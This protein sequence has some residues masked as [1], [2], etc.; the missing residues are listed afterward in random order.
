M[1]VIVIMGVIY[2]LSVTSFPKQGDEEVTNVDLLSLK[3]YL[4]NLEYEENIRVLCLDDCRDCDIIVDGEKHSTIENLVDDNT[5]VY[6]YDYLLG[7]QERM[8][9]VYFNEEDVQEDVCFSYTIDKQGVGDQVLVEF[10]EEVY[11]FS[12]YITDTQKYSSM[13][14]CLSAKAQLIEEVT[15]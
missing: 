8:K 1:I 4:T 10:K 2:T 14:E 7:S 11:D 13:E 6:R 15:R 5:R 12:T 3:K 9:E